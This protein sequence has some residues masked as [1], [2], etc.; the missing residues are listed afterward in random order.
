MPKAMA[1][2]RRTFLNVALLIKVYL[3]PE[4]AVLNLSINPRHAQMPMV[5]PVIKVQV[6]DT[7]IV[8]CAAR[9]SC[10]W[11]PCLD[12]MSH[13]IIPTEIKLWKWRVHPHQKMAPTLGGNCPQ[14]HQKKITAMGVIDHKDG[15][16]DSQALIVVCHS[17]ID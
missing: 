1:C 6:T 5:T 7:F 9:H 4:W 10:V 11:V 16:A 8:F 3:S 17:Q 14:V 12:A 2:I 13:L 15:P